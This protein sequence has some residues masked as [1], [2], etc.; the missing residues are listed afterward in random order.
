MQE[1]TEQ[2]AICFN[3]FT[4][5]ARVDYHVYVTEQCTLFQ[6]LINTTEDKY[7]QLPKQHYEIQMRLRLSRGGFHLQQSTPCRRSSVLKC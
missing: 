7:L 6:D 1:D 2:W 5:T 4:V 3:N